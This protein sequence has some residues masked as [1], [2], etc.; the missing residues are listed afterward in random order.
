M[1]VNLRKLAK[2]QECQLRLIDDD[3]VWVCNFDSDTVVLCHLRLTGVAGI[4]QKPSD[5]IA[6]YGC[7]ACHDVVDGRS[8]RKVS[9]LDK[10]KLRALAGTLTIVGKELGIG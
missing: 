1:K 6:V 4:G 3:G 8:K 9:T 5:L 7:S 10:D 2:G